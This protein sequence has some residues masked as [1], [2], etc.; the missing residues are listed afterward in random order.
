MTYYIYAIETDPEGVRVVYTENIEEAAG[1]QLD[2][3]GSYVEASV[4]EEAMLATEPVEPSGRVLYQCDGERCDRCYDAC[5]KTSDI[6]H[7][8][9]FYGTADGD[10]Y[11]KI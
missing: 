10:Y 1:F 3:A 5:V 8:V 9:N 7:A 11:E 4:T 2:R 6:K